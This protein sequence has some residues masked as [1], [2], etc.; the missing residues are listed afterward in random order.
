MAWKIGIA[1]DHV[2]IIKGFESM[3]QHLSDCTFIFGVLSGTELLLKLEQEKPDILLLDINIP[4]M[5]GVELCKVISFKYPAVKIIALTS[6]EETMYVKKMMRNGASGYLLKSIDPD[7]FISA[8]RTVMGGSQFIDTR[9]QQIML[10]ESIYGRKQTPG[11]VLT[12]REIEVL[13]MIAEE[14]SNQQIAQKLFI[15]LRTVETHRFNLIRK[16]EVKN[17]AGLVKEAYLR[18]LVK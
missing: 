8:I 14:Q 15:S 5:S 6:H 12:K 17:T 4:G 11:M 16:L 1:D 7:T 10:A 2:M 3:L 18:G 9:L 13:V